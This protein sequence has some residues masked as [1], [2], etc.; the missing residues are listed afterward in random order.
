MSVDIGEI[1]LTFLVSGR[2]AVGSDFRISLLATTK[3]VAPLGAELDKLGEVEPPDDTGM[4][5]L[6]CNVACSSVVV[7]K[8][9]VVPLGLITCKRSL[10]VTNL[11]ILSGMDS[12]EGGAHPSSAEQSSS[13][14]PVRST[15][16]AMIAIQ[17]RSG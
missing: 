13:G 3:S 1:R 14:D 5:S 8:E 12:I 10:L 2:V 15:V 17:I 9:T 16:F 6:S 11:G 4:F 7:P